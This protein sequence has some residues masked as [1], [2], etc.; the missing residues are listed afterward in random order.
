MK[1]IT[2]E[3]KVGAVALLTIIVFVW[4]FNFLKGK[5]LLTRTKH[6]YVVYNKINGLAES[7]PVE[8]NGFKVGVVQSIQFIN[9]GSGRLVAKLSVEKNFSLPKNTIAEITTA[10]FIAGMKIQ[11]IFGE[12]P[13]FYSKGDTIPGR[14]AV[15]I[16]TRFESEFT[17]I[18]EKVSK[19][20]VVLDSAISSVNDILIPTFIKNMQ[21][22]MANINSTTKNVDEI[23]LSNQIRLKATLANISKFSQMLADNSGKIGNTI[24]NLETITD[25]L[26]TDSLYKSLANLKS[27]LER[28]SLLMENLNTGK[29]TAGQLFTN[30]TLYQNMTNSLESLNLL[31]RDIKANPK[32]YVHFSIFGKKS[33][34][35]K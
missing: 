7:S 26:A 32:K 13:G 24:A 14:L 25:T 19:M 22:S 31:L 23:I 20:I 34:P 3:V 33:L 2:N 16:L 30:D 28:T 17:P 6:Y 4:L 11:F 9:D 29:G 35:S 1:K 18:L 15:S 10:T 27:T 8:I 12:G 21:E 5:D